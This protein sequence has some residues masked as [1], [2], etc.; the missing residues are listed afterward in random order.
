METTC[1]PNEH[2]KFA[3]A[4]ENGVESPKQ[5]LLG[6]CK[7]L[8]AY[9]LT[10]KKLAD[11]TIALNK[12]QLMALQL[13][14]ANDGGAMHLHQI[15]MTKLDN[16][17]RV[18]I[19]IA[20]ECRT[21]LGGNGITAEYSPLRHANNLESVRAYEGTDEVHTLIVGQKFT[22]EGAFSKQTWNAIPTS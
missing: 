2:T 20:R 1:G 10:H 18:S 16:D 15:S 5:F 11:V 19:E 8:T 7:P 3:K 4:E 9:Q 13:G 12:S 6:L 14:R 22:G 21:I 17:V